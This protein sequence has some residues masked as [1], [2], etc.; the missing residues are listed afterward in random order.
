MNINQSELD[1]LIERTRQGELTPDQANV[2][3]VRM[4]RV[5]LVTSRI[6]AQVRRAL[7]EAVK[8]GEL[9]HIKKDGHKPEAYFHPNFE[10]MVAGELNSHESRIIAA[11]S[12][13]LCSMSDLCEHQSTTQEAGR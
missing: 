3:K 5:S 12:K 11:T 6:P 4:E 13:V 1:R 2:L 9:G 8:R 7:N 10:F